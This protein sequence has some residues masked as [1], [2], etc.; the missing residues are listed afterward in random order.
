MPARKGVKG[1]KKAAASKKSAFVRDQAGLFKGRSLQAVTSRNRFLA[2]MDEAEASDYVD[3]FRTQQW[4][5]A[6][7]FVYA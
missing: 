4:T 3:E 7:R 5:T 1:T 2:L 6:Q